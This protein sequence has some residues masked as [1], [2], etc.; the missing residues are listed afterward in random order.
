MLVSASTTAGA[1]CGAAAALLFYSFAAAADVVGFVPGS[2]WLNL[3][4]WLLF[5]PTAAAVVLALI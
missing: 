5:L 1:N 4:C 2:F 3:V